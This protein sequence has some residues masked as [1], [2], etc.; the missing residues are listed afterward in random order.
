M[1]EA[2]PA[3]A[4]VRAELAE[5]RRK[6]EECLADVQQFLSHDTSASR[7]ELTRALRQRADFIESQVRG[8]RAFS[9]MLDH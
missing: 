8:D 7:V 3:V 2:S 4:R 6:T 1:T 5:E 9:R